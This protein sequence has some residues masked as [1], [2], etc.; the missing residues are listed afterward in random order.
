M[1]RHLT[2][3]QYRYKNMV[4]KQVLKEVQSQD[5]ALTL[6]NVWFNVYFLGCKYPEQIMKEVEKFTP[7]EY[8]EY[9]QR[10]KLNGN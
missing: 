4:Y 10:R 8:L 9:A 5:R 1:E 2:S 7:A 3:F 6:A